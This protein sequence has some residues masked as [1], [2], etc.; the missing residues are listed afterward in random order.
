VHLDVLGEEPLDRGSATLE[1][2][3]SGEG[4]GLSEWAIEVSYEGSCQMDERILEQPDTL[5]EVLAPLGRAVASV[6]VRIGD[7]P[8]GFRPVKDPEA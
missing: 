3:L 6:L 1:Q 8:F 2:V 5:D 4:H 7:L